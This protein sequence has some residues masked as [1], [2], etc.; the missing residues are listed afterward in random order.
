[1]PR[2]LFV[3]C[4]RMAGDDGP[5][6]RSHEPPAAEGSISA[7]SR[8]FSCTGVSE[9][10]ET[11]NRRQDVVACAK[12]RADAPGPAAS[13]T[14]KAEAQAV[15]LAAGA[16]LLADQAFFPCPFP[17]PCRIVT[18]RSRTWC[19]RACDP[20]PVRLPRS[21]SAGRVSVRHRPSS[22][23]APLSMIRNIL[24]WHDA[25]G[26]AGQE[27]GQGGEPSSDS[28]QTS[29]LQGVATCPAV[30]SLEA[31]G[32]PVDLTGRCRFPAHRRRKKG[33]FEEV[34]VAKLPRRRSSLLPRTFGR[35]GLCRSPTSR[36]RATI[37]LSLD[38]VTLG[39]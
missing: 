10:D 21:E 20:A 5:A 32:Q 2:P 27:G 26:T 11:A 6:G 30:P 12:R 22:R 25:V 4:N 39:Q 36:D 15:A 14:V 3:E 9:S 29:I 35:T 13:R 16:A 7:N 37:N 33:G 18:S 38:L 23:R 8:R 24:E 31:F 19:V 17:V 1:M 34:I 28:L